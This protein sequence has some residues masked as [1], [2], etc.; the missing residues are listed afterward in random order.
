[1]R[2]TNPPVLATTSRS[3][4]WA[5]VVRL[6]LAATVTTVAVPLRAEKL[7]TVRAVADAAYAARRAKE[8]PPPVETYVL[9]KGQ[10]SP[11]ITTDSSLWDMP[12]MTMAKT[13]AGELRQQ[14]YEPAQ[15]LANADLVI[16]I[17]WGVTLGNDRG[18]ALLD[19]QLAGLT[20][21]AA[22]IDEAKAA[23]AAD[24]TGALGPIGL[25]QAAETNFNTEAS[26]A[27]TLAAGSNFTAASNAELLGLTSALREE[28]EAIFD[29]DRARTLRAMVNEERY[30]II[31]MA[32]DAKTLLKDRKTKRLWTSRL[33]IRSAGVSFATAV[34]RMSSAGGLFFGTRQPAV[35]MQTTKEKVGEVKIGEL[36]V[37]GEK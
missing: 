33:S 11:G 8:N 28:G 14:H 1:M 7:V 27:N 15:S 26:A 3:K 10:Y 31:L 20:D 30:F 34:S 37:L 6:G 25:I 17:H 16:V 2:A 35:V 18:G 32:Y 13:V 21:V 4:L 36:K 5:L 19:L 22:Q 24:N 9:A 23:V 12:F 29:T